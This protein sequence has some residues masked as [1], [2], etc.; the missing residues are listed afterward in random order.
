MLVAVGFRRSRQPEWLSVADAGELT[1][2]LLWLETLAE[3]GRLSSFPAAVGLGF[4]LRGP[5]P[6][7]LELASLGVALGAA[8]DPMELDRGSFPAG[9]LALERALAA[10]SAPGLPVLTSLPA[11]ASAGIADFESLAEA[12]RHRSPIVCEMVLGD[13]RIAVAEA[14][15]WQIART[16]AADVR[17]GYELG[18]GLWH[19]LG[20]EGGPVA[21]V[22]EPPWSGEREAFG[23]L[24]DP[25]A[26]RSE[27]KAWMEGE[28]RP[29][30][31]VDTAGLARWIEREGISPESLRRLPQE[32][33]LIADAASA[34]R[35]ACAERALVAA[36]PERFARAALLSGR[37][38]LVLA[39]EREPW[40]AGGVVV[41]SGER[42][43]ATPGLWLLPGLPDAPGEQ[44][45]HLFATG[46]APGR[47]VPASRI[48][49]P[50]DA[51]VAVVTWG[52]GEEIA[53]RAL[54]ICGPE[55]ASQVGLVLLHQLAPPP[56]EL[57]ELLYVARRVIVVAGARGRP[58]DAIAAWLISRLP[59]LERLEIREH[60]AGPGSIAVTIKAACSAAG[61]A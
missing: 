5:E 57:L 21:L 24:R 48:S 7:V 18:A 14:L 34:L 16:P 52:D 49:G 37:V 1:R 27:A 47:A 60:V 33:P 12:A 32:V 31:Q 25:E 15:G 45:L 4:G 6:P 38:P 46:A 22:F 35:Y 42:L 11:A 19:R 51:P 56:Q 8:R 50:G 61:T 28:A 2:R 43:P 39:E 44:A 41:W 58:A 20:L 54:A 3:G 30:R 59:Q 9:Q 13:P 53:G 26:P 36:D 10:S 17:A 29:A 55:I 40:A 23:F